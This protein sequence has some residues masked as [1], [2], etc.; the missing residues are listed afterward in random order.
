MCQASRAES[1]C[2]GD[3]DEAPGDGEYNPDSASSDD[4][5]TIEQEEIQDP[6][7]HAQNE[8]KDLEQ[9]ADV[10]IEELLRKYYPDEF[11][12]NTKGY[13]FIMYCFPNY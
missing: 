9:G 3:T 4:E 11:S 1:V 12:H 10:P 13:S 2:S 5:E 7:D 6:D 8:L